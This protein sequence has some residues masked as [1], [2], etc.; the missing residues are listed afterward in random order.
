MAKYKTISVKDLYKI[1]EGL[2]RE[3]AKDQGFYTPGRFSSRVINSEKNNAHFKFR[4]NK[5]KI[6]EDL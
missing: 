5:H 2:N 1:R 6:E 3:S 4:K